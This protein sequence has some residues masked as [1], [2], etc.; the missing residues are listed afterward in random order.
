MKPNDLQPEDPSRPISNGMR[1][2]WFFG[3][4]FLSLLLTSLNFIALENFWYWKFPWFDILMHI[5]GGLTLGSFMIALFPRHRPILYM[6]ALTVFFIG[7]EIIEYVGGI[8]T[9]EANYVFDTAHD[10]LNDAIGSIVVY[11]IARFSL[12]R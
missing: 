9:H 8:T 2:Y 1:L 5:L 10:L 12:W 4:L 11:M 6:G 3:A 7:W